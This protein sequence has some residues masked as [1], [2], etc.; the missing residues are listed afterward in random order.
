V[1]LL[2][3]VYSQSKWVVGLIIL[4]VAVLLFG[5]CVLERFAEPVYRPPVISR[6]SASPEQVG[7]LD[8]CQIKCVASDPDG[9]ILTYIWLANGGKISGEGAVVTWTAPDAPGI[10]TI[11]VRVNDG[12]DNEATGEV[13]IEVGDNH[14]P[15]IDNLT[16]TNSLQAG[17]PMMKIAE[18]ANIKCI[19]SDPDGDVLSYVWS[20]ERGNISGTGAAVGWVTP[21]ATGAY[22]ITVTVADGKGG[23]ATEE[24]LIRVCYCCCKCP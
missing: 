23:G 8:N 5:G 1:K 11:T 7:Q 24:L 4:V 9:D 2:K 18:T 21:N 6:L 10:Y 20:A 22:K 16:V 12:R 17:C 14:I 3:L 13:T 19:A 15:V